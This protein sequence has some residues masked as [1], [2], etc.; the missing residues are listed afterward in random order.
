VLVISNHD[1]RVT[2][3]V[4]RPEAAILRPQLFLNEIWRRSGTF[5]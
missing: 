4:F 3:E 5:A 2:I 1:R